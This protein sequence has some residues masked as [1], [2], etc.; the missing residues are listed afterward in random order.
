[1]TKSNRTTSVPTPFPQSFLKF[2]Q[3]CCS[4]C[5]A[6]YTLRKKSTLHM[7]PVKKGPSMKLRRKG[8]P[9]LGNTTARFEFLQMGSCASRGETE[10]KSK[11]CRYVSYTDDLHGY[12]N[13]RHVM[14]PRPGLWNLFLPVDSSRDGKSGQVLAFDY[15]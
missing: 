5:R 8:K 14:L 3:S 13:P 4:L 11:T 2:G 6:K 7:S 10:A 9:C 1:M 15:T 12:A